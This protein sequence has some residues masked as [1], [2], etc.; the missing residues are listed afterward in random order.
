MTCYAY[1]D[2][3]HWRSIYPEEVFENQLAKLCEKWA[4]GLAL[5]TD[6]GSELSIMAKAA[7]IQFS[8][9]RNQVRFYRARNAG[10]TATMKAM[11]EKELEN[12]KEMLALMNRTPVL[13]FEAANHYYFSKGNIAE[14]I[15]NCRKI[16]AMYR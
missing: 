6:D 1:D 12:A 4:E 11:A 3:E 7:Y 9:C 2:L 5:L 8:A 13:G 16:L 14:K 15:L 10:D